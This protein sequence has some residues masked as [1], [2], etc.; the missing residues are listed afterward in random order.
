MKKFEPFV[1]I[2]EDNVK[3]LAYLFIL[4]KEEPWVVAVV[5]SYLRADLARQL[6]TSLPI[7]LQAKV[8]LE[9][10]TV[11]QVTRDQ[12]IAIDNDVKENV[13]FVVGGIERLVSMLD[14]SDS[15]TR[16]NIL[17]YLKN[18]KPLVYE[19][20][21]KHLLIFE[22]I[23]EFPDR[24]MQAIV[25]ELK[26]DMMAKALVGAPPEVLNKF[27]SSMSAGA[28]SLLK[29]TM[30]YS[31]GLS[32][33]QIEDERTKVMDVIKTLEKEGK[34]SV[35]KQDQQ[36]YDM[37]E[38]M[39]EELGA[40]ERRQKRFQSAR[41]KNA[42]QE[43]PTDPAKA[44]AYF[45]AALSQYQSGQM[46]AAI[47]YFEAA[48][49]LNNA[50]WQAHQYLGAILYQKGN[51]QDAL[52]HYEKVLEHNPDPQIKAWVESF[53]AQTGGNSNG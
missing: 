26:T 4:R 11:R 27:F 3:R 38:G 49:S 10:L 22:D 51:V 2:N 20:V 53:K 43:T 19:A 39:Q 14:E 41:Q 30:E 8:A 9:A 1:Y 18:E 15:A 29:E 46:E 42:P 21:R 16:T 13:D 32:Q 25:R 34:I 40:S 23:A 33:N 35:R 24:E 48:L 47:P 44:Q 7:N 45:D 31:Q 50:L 5:A 52:I 36:G 17:N 28:A 12:V 37:V 6:L